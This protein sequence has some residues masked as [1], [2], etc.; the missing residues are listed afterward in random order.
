M[1]MIRNIFKLS[2]LQLLYDLFLLSL[3]ITFAMTVA[4]FKMVIPPRS[5]SLLGETV[6]VN[7]SDI[8]N[9]ISTA[10][11]PFSHKLRIR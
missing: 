10:T 8:P 4:S 6:L 7:E 9:I 11:F 3:K 5:K 2:H 1:P